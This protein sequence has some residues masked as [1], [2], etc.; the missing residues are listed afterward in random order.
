MSA[1]KRSTGSFFMVSREVKIY[2]DP[3]VFG[4]LYLDPFFIKDFFDSLRNRFDS[5]AAFR[6]ILF[7][8]FVLL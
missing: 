6:S 1:F 4:I 8:V 2:G 3:Y 5:V 7:H